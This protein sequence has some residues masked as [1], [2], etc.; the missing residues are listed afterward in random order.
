MIKELTDLIKSISSSLL[1]VLL[2]FLFEACWNFQLPT[3][4]NVL[5]FS[6]I[7]EEF[8]NYI[9]EKLVRSLLCLVRIFVVCKYPTSTLLIGRIC[10]YNSLH[11]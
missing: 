5:S 8:L 11:P 6:F 1:L 10:L 7:C 9:Y 4:F 3:S 2:E